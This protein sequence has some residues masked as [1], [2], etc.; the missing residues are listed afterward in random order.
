MTNI[1]TIDL[2]KFRSEI[3]KFMYI[4]EGN[5]AKIDKVM[6]RLDSATIEP[7][8]DGWEEA[9]RLIPDIEE[10]SNEVCGV[11]CAYRDK[12]IDQIQAEGLLH[13]YNE[14]LLAKAKAEW[15]EE[16]RIHN[17][18]QENKELKETIQR[19]KTRCTCTVSL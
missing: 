10:Y 15:I 8:L 18:E 2:D 11:V 14:S 13:L 1:V 19:I 7:S 17:L 9:R 6:E 12:K 5:Q 4:V 3:E 16:G